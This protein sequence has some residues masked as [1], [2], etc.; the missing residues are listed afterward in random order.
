VFLVKPLKNIDEVWKDQR[1]PTDEIKRR[2]LEVVERL[3]PFIR[4]V[5]WI[6]E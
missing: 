2:R 1:F 5:I 4:V 3:Y 6:V